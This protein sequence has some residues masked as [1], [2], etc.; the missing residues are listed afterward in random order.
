MFRVIND[1]DADCV[2]RANYLTIIRKE[3]GWHSH[4]FVLSLFTERKSSEQVAVRFTRGCDWLRGWP[5][6]KA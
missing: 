3:M 6:H 2:T 5:N 1:L 4:S